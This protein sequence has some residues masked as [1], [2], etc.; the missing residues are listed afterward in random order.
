M[1]KLKG[2]NAK[3]ELNPVHKVSRR[4]YDIGPAEAPGEPPAMAAA[5]GAEPDERRVREV[6]EATLARLA[7]DLQVKAD[8]S[9]LRFDRVKHT[10]LGSHV[11]FQQYHD[12]KPISDAWI[13]IDLDREGRVYN[14]QNDLIPTAVL[15]KAATKAVAAAAKAPS[16]D[17]AI[18][19]AFAAVGCAKSRSKEVLEA[20]LVYYPVESIPKL[21]WKVVLKADRP[22]G[23]WKVYVDAR[24]DKT[25]L[26]KIDL[27]KTATGRGRV[28]DPN[29]VVALDDP[30]LSDRSKIPA[31]AYV[32]VD[33]PGLD[34]TGFLDGPFV[35]TRRS[36]SRVKKKTLKFLMK[37]TQKGFKEVMVYFHID[38]IQRHI[39]AMGFTNVLNRQIEVSIDGRRDDN[40]DYSSLTKALRFGLG[41]VDDAEDAEIILHEYGHAIQDDQV[42]GW[43]ASHEAG[44]MGEGFGDYLAGSFFE[45][46]KSAPLKPTVGSWDATA[47]S[48]ANPPALRRLDSPKR[49]PRDIDHEVHDDGEIWSACLWQLRA[50]IGD[51]A[52]ADRLVLAHHFLLTRTASFRDAVNALLT[53]DRNLNGGRHKAVIR[54][55]FTR[56]GIL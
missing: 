38:R 54:N 34:G 12:G 46:A 22:L 4:I 25:V 52:T 43:G 5:A 53:A 13:R 2:L 26:G 51:R 6:A 10:L 20:Q 50:A 11:L 42:P 44:A 39:Q 40:S 28:F 17:R 29:P 1:R 47:Y 27:I 32:E 36:S 41:G 21:A 19:R 24:D 14:I 37:R 16:P 15:E 55:V 35:S 18:R 49:Y 7:G 3:V 56:R 45:A 23:E 30:R 48:D 33:L 8:L 31:Q 9:S